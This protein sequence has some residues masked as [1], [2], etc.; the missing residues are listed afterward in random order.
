MKQNGRL[1]HKKRVTAKMLITTNLNQ[2]IEDLMKTGEEKMSHAQIA[3]KYRLCAR[4]IDRIKAKYVAY[5]HPED[6][7]L[8]EINQTEIFKRAELDVLSRLKMINEDSISILEL[9]FAAM[10]CMLEAEIASHTK[11]QKG[12]TCKTGDLKPR[13]ITDFVMAVAPYVM[14]KKENRGKPVANEKAATGS[15]LR[16]RWLNSQKDKTKLV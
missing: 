5:R 12:E 11:F 7:K 16:E 1:Y 14:Q 6:V 3:K 9:S 10:R 4:T 13:E 15:D 2:I 8:P